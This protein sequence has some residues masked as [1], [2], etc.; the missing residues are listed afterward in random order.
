M[1]I[2]V[3]DGPQ[4]T[5]LF[6]FFDIQKGYVTYKGRTLK[7]GDLSNDYLRLAAICLALLAPRP[8]LP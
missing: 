6:G 1:E 3:Q 4:M 7:S 8:V 5:I 2:I